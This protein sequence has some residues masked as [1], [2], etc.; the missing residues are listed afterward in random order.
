MLRKRFFCP[1]NNIIIG[2]LLVVNKFIVCQ[3][4]CWTTFDTKENYKILKEL[5]DRYANVRQNFHD[6]VGGDDFDKEMLMALL[7][8][9]GIAERALH[10]AEGDWTV[11]PAGINLGGYCMM[12][13]PT[14]MLFF[15]RMKLR[16]NTI[17]RITELKNDFKNLAL[18]ARILLN[19]LYLF[20]SYDVT[21][22]TKP[23]VLGYEP[24]F[25][26]V[27]I[28]L[29]NVKY[30]V[31]GRYRLLKN[32]LNIE[33]IVSEL[34][35]PEIMMMYRNKN[36]TEEVQLKEKNIAEFSQKL[37]ADL[38]KWLKDYF[39]DYLMH[40]V[41]AD[42]KNFEKYNREKTEVLNKFTDKTIDKIVNRIH[43]IKA[44]AVRLPSFTIYIA[45]FKEIRLRD[46]VL[47]G[48][49]NIYRR[50]ITT[51]NTERDYT[52]W[53][54]DTV[55]GFSDLKLIYRYDAILKSGLPPVTGT[56]ILTADE[57]TAHMRLTSVIDSGD[58][59]LSFKFLEQRKPESL[60]VEG[61]ANRMISNFKLILERHIIAIMSNTLMHNINMLSTI[62]RCV[63]LLTAYTGPKD[64]DSYNKID[65]ND[66]NIDDNEINNKNVNQGNEELQRSSIEQPQ[67]DKILIG[68]TSS[69]P[70]R[71]N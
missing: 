45:H 14:S 60:I 16:N 8:N 49:D 66:N 12:K 21:T 68:T 53:N 28:L 41:V 13:L 52:F 15:H 6:T 43:E 5:D 48:L 34:H 57:L 18:H 59:D 55:V 25:G 31:E 4:H 61:P 32:R 71:S 11:I 2:F 69:E 17:F 65:E 19:D 58:T 20:G 46:G 23:G 30:T 40:Y 26:Q 39:N 9:R 29:K 56:L 50:A 70:V 38:D 51:A 27:E 67:T 35:I 63:P 47:R 42:D 1:K 10:D 54:V 36:S 24:S 22:A 33:M 64:L 3:R 62:S 37:K 7:K 44:N